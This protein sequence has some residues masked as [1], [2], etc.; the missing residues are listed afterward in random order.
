MNRTVLIIEDD[1]AIAAVMQTIL[2]SEGYQVLHAVDGDGFAAALA[3]QPTLI[4][5][6]INMPGMDGPEVSHYLRAHPRT[7][8]IPIIAMSAQGR[9]P[10]LPPHMQADDYLAKPFEVDD[11]CQKV[12]RWVQP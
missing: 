3:A 12:E 1:T 8:H 9:P 5:L 10:V 4:F 6:D 7:A 11:L 2:E